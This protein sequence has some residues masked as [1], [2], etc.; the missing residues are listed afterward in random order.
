MLVLLQL[1]VSWDIFNKQANYGYWPIL[2]A[3]RLNGHFGAPQKLLLFFFLKFSLRDSKHL[4]LV[5]CIALVENL[6]LLS[7]TAPNVDEIHVMA[8]AMR[9]ELP[10]MC[11]QMFSHQP[12]WAEAKKS[13]RIKSKGETERKWMRES[14][15]KCGR[16]RRTMDRDRKYKMH[17]PNGK[18]FGVM[19]THSNVR[20]I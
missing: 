1:F 4:I 3:L 18:M 20:T 9:P 13:N 19:S 6:K 11:N 2:D 10:A 16:E 12:K 8:I 14:G 17:E 15:R 5:Y 7:P